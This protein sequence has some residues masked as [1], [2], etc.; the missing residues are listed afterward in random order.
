MPSLPLSFHFDSS[1]QVF[2]RRQQRNVRFLTW[3]RPIHSR[4][5]I[6]FAVSENLAQF[7]GKRR[8]VC[9]S[10]LIIA[11]GALYGELAVEA[12]SVLL[13]P[14]RALLQDLLQREKGLFGRINWSRR[15]SMKMDVCMFW[16]SK[17]ELLGLLR[18]SRG[19]S[20]LAWLNAVAQVEEEE[21][22][23]ARRMRLAPSQPVA[24]R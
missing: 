3:F 5:F 11:A 2:S 9:L 15:R 18:Q 1:P 14:L 12:G 16:E 6:A 21:E 17:C 19:R 8:N 10:L 7:R 4:P 13:C 24:T 23:G 20:V 22:R